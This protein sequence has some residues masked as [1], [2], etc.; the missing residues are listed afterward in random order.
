M[1][2]FTKF[3]L[4]VTATLSYAWCGVASAFDNGPLP[5]HTGALGQPDC[6]VCHS[7]NSA[8]S[9]GGSV[10]LSGLPD[11]FLAG[12][13][14][15]I[16]VALEDKKLSSGGF[17]LTI[18]DTGG[19]SVGEF[20]ANQNDVKIV[21]DGDTGNSYVQHGTPRNKRTDESGI[22]WTVVWTA[23]ECNALVTVAVAAVAAND[24]A[25]PLGDNVYTTTARASSPGADLK[26]EDR[27][28]K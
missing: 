25:S 21:R 6:T 11:T 20:D 8:N 24:D 18:R 14:Y 27:R 3:P 19:V 7:D 10:T 15:S 17:Q 9:Q 26:N 28:K 13:Q 22:Q 16:S 2:R 23:P 12:Q 4:A 5:G 1:R